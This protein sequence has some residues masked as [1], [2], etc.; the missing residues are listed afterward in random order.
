FQNDDMQNEILVDSF[1]LGIANSC[2]V[3][4]LTETANI[5]AGALYELR[6]K[7]IFG[8]FKLDS[9]CCFLFKKDT[10]ISLLALVGIAFRDGIFYSNRNDLEVY[11]HEMAGK[12]YGVSIFE[13]LLEMRIFICDYEMF[14]C[15]EGMFNMSH[16]KDQ[17]TK[18][19]GIRM[20]NWKRMD[21][22]PK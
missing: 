15:E 18:N 16:W 7:M 6:Q 20:F 2:N 12:R 21:I 17:E 9:L 1:L 11:G 14:D 10:C 5:T 3:V 13:G 8:A 22:Y 19:N 4:E